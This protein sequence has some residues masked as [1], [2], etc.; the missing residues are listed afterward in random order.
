MHFLLLSGSF[1]H[2][3]RSLHILH[4]V[5]QQLAPHSSEIPALNKLPF[6]DAELNH[7]KPQVVLDLIRQC[8]AADGIIICTPEYNHSLPAVIKN[9]IDWLSRPA[10]ASP[11]KN[12]PV[13][14]ITQADSPVGGARAQA[15]LKLVLDATLSRVLPA[16]EMMIPAISQVLDTQGQIQ[17]AQVADR[18]QRYLAAF[19]AYSAVQ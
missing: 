14:V 17:D 9:A 7:H 4:Y 10:F 12:K 13:A 15:H 16:H 8:E 19:V 18:L 5:Q 6:F 2:N 1:H 3:S 11:L